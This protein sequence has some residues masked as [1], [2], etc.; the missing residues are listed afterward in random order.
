[1]LERIELISPEGFR[2]GSLAGAFRYARPDVEELWRGTSTQPIDHGFLKYLELPAQSYLK[3][4]WLGELHTDSGGHFQFELPPIS[5]DPADT[6][7]SLLSYASADRPNIELL[8]RDHALPALERLQAYFKRS[9]AIESVAQH[10]EPPSAPDISVVVPLY[11]R[12]DLVE[13]QIAQFWRDPE[14]AEAELIYVLDSPAHWPQ[15]STIAA[16]LHALYGLPFTVLKLNRN[17]GFA[18]ANNVAASHARGR[19][20][21]LLNSDV[22]PTVPGWLGTMRSFYDATPGIGALGPKLLYEDESIQHAGMYFELDPTTNL[23]ENQHYYKGFSRSLGV[24]NVSRPVPA[25]TGACMM[26][27]R[28][29][30]HHVGGLREDYIQG[31]FEDSDLCLR[32]IEAGYENWYVATVEL[33][34]LEAQSFPIELRATKRYNGWLQTHLWDQRIRDVMRKQSEPTDA[35]VTPVG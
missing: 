31:G 19:L 26:V 32:L 3:E 11:E 1:V 8:R 4:G 29:V 21:L 6:R 35:R 23:W 14:L 10:G 27:D 33:Y 25:V 22:L 18:A 2:A 16:E 30:Y 24:A 13:H 20:L 34:H 7:G 15:L 28:S 17:G 5:R 12:I 9:L